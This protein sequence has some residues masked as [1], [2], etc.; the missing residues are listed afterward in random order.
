MFSQL[1]AGNISE[2]LIHSPASLPPLLPLLL[3][4]L[5]LFPPP[6][7]PLLLC[8]LRHADLCVSIRS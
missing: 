3:L 7:L 5:L 1:T 4:L 8:S 2:P 6:P